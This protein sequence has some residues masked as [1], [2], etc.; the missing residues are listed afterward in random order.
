M[1]QKESRQ[2]IRSIVTAPKF[3]P[4]LKKLLKILKP[5]DRFIMAF[6]DDKAPVLDVYYAFNIAL[7][8][9]IK[10]MPDISETKRNYLLQLN[11]SW[12]MFMYGE[13]HGIGFLLD[14]RNIGDGMPSE[15]AEDMEAI[16]FGFLDS[17]TSNPVPEERRVQ[18]YSEY[19]KFQIHPHRQK[20]TN[21]FRHKMLMNKVKKVWEYWLTDGVQ[22]PLLQKIA[23]KVFSMCASSAA[24]ERNFSTFGFVRSKLQ[25]CFQ[26]GTVEKLVYIKTNYLQLSDDE[27]LAMALQD[28]GNRDNDDDDDNNADEDIMEENVVEVL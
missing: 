24:S 25:N 14:P 9:A 28:E 5:M 21:S 2:P 8:K 11:E 16:I 22:W 3:I 26:P 10:D 18:V 13:A 15:D 12:F 23:L 19:T 20:Q 6:Q 27:V 7:P 17:D 1:K 4:L